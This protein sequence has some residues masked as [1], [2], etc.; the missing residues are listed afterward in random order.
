MH[1]F[2]FFLAF[3]LFI[4]W[5]CMIVDLNCKVWRCLQDIR[6]VDLQK[7]IALTQVG[8]IPVIEETVIN[9]LRN[10][11]RRRWS[12]HKRA[13]R[14]RANTA[15]KRK[16]QESKNKKRKRL[17]K[18]R[19]SES[20]KRRHAKEVCKGLQH[21]L[22]P[23]NIPDKHGLDPAVL[24]VCINYSNGYVCINI[25][26]FILTLRACVTG[27]CSCT[28]SRR[29]TRICQNDVYARRPQTIR[30]QGGLHRS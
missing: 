27:K 28:G 7:S 23:T 2:V 18:L 20:A 15:K 21:V 26:Q 3:L 30:Y 19:E 17:E 10:K 1:C 13:Q 25:C 12:E 29:E 4:Q 22:V 14:E 24:K 9:K 8:S 16:Q 11:Q 6:P 5:T